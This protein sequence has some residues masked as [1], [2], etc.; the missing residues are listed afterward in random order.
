MDTIEFRL[1]YRSYAN[2][3]YSDSAVKIF[4]NGEDL[5]PRIHEFEKNVGCKGR[6]APLYVSTLYESLNEDYKIDSVPIYGCGCGDIDCSAIYITVEVGEKTVTWKNFILPDE[7]L[8]EE[9]IYPR[10]FGELVFGKEQYFR[11]VEKLKLWSEDDSL[12]V[13]YGGIEGGEVKIVVK[14]NVQTFEFYFDET[15]D[16]PL[17]DFVKFFNA[18]RGGEEYF[19]VDIMREDGHVA[20][21]LSIKRWLDG[22]V[23]FYVELVGEELIFCE[24]LQR[25]KLAAMFKKIFDALLNDKYFPYSYP[26]FWYLGISDEKYFDN[27][28]DKIEEEHPDWT[29]GDVFNYAVAEKKCKL[30]PPYEKY[31]EHY[32][33]MLTDYVIPDKW[34]E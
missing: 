3:D 32:K 22:Q 17:P 29:I 26:C 6:H 25:E 8:R 20:F 12:S 19:S 34:F 7:N 27:V 33:K 24:Y 9:I 1:T 18:V 11:E 2:H 13:E 30:A 16:D 28:T 21:K 4:I 31:L 14:K 10:R 15:L 5:L 23:R